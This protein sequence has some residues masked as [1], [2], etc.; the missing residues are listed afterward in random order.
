VEEKV[1]ERAAQKLRLDQLVIQ[2][3]RSSGPSK[4]AL[5]AN[6]DCLF[7][8]SNPECLAGPEKGDLVEM[9]QHGSQK[10]I[11]GKEDMEIKDDIDAIIARGQ[12]KTAEL[13]AKYANVAFDD[14]HSFKSE[15]PATNVWEGE[16][17]KRKQS[18]LIWIEPT[19]RERKA[20]PWANGAIAPTRQRRP[21]QLR[22]KGQV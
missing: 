20:N 10:I 19:K 22:L 15:L 1:L 16:T 18:G 7:Q 9:I 2:Q 6:L 12:A 11:S 4:G 13:N 3:G 14:L 17:V 8:R 5:V 21:R